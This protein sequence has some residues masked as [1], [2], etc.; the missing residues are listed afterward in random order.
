[1][2][3]DAPP[4][5]EAVSAF[6]AARSCPLRHVLVAVSGGPDSVA[7]LHA[8]HSLTAV[9][10]VHSQLRVAH[11]NHHLRGEASE[12]DAEYVR[13]LATSLNLPFHL[14]ESQELSPKQSH[15]EASARKFRYRWLMDTAQSQG[16]SAIVTGHT[17]N[18]QAETV[19]H[20]LIR[21]T[22]WRGLR[23]IAPVRKLSHEVLLLRPLLCCSRQQVLDYLYEFKL[24]P[25]QD[26][27]NFDLRFTRNRLRHQ[28]LPQLVAHFP[29]AVRYL[30]DWADVARDN[31]AA[32][33]RTVRLGFSGLIVH[34]D[35]KQ[36]AIHRFMVQRAG[37]D[38]LQEVLRQLW[39]QQRWPVDQMNA[40]RWHEV[41]EVCR[42]VRTVVELP[43][44]I[45]VRAKALVI[46]FIK[47]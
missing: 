11:F 5:I 47:L 25:C 24:S 42:G 4:L 15:L 12:A 45:M 30:A 26:E 46:Q 20:H 10:V 27:S 23:G 6:W 38:V 16:C 33:Q 9:G 18:D 1:M 8:L 2:M 32:I 21:G 35:E 44:R 13:H 3:S 37:D 22:G 7:L 43:G 29:N 19:L 40:D 28:T 41:C 17:L 36:V 34:K 39:K 14:G 31:Y